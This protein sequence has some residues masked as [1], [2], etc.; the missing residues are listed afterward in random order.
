MG[1]SPRRPRTPLGSQKARAAGFLDCTG[2][3]F[4]CNGD[5]LRPFSCV[6]SVVD[7]MEKTR[8]YFVVGE[9]QKTWRHRSY[10]RSGLW[11]WSP[12]VP[13]RASEGNV[14]PHR[15]R[16]APVFQEVRALG[17]V[18]CTGI[19]CGA[20]A[21]DVATSLES[22]RGDVVA[23]GAAASEWGERLAAHHHVVYWN[24][25]KRRKF[26]FSTCR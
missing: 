2:I 22:T 9:L 17:L 4:G 15:P 8:A 20:V 3:D 23:L 24:I 16:T 10:Q 6:Y 19:E 18:D 14:S 11:V 1:A 13:S 5:L 7:H 12:E 26:I 25:F 21:E